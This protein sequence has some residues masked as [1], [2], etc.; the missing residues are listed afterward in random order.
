MKKNSKSTPEKSSFKN[1]KN[2]AINNYNENKKKY[3][4]YNESNNYNQFSLVDSNQS[5][6]KSNSS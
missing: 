5:E 3:I 6:K 4:M 2:E 1:Q